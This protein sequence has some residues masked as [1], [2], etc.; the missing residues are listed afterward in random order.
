MFQKNRERT[1][2]CV[3]DGGRPTFSQGTQE[4]YV[5]VVREWCTT[6]LLV[7]P[8]FPGKGMGIFQLFGGVLIGY[9]AYDFF[10]DGRPFA[11][12]MVIVVGMLVIFADD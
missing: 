8:L 1:F 10:Y 4:A 11:G 7:F 9:I 2:G 6:V 12:I 5:E 3:R